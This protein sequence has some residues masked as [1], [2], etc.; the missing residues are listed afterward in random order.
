MFLELHKVSHIWPFLSVSATKLLDYVDLPNYPLD[1][2]QR[3][4]N[5]ATYFLLEEKVNYAKPLLWASLTAH[6][7]SHYLQN[8]HIVL[9]LSSQSWLCI[10][11]SLSQSLQS[12]CVVLYVLCIRKKSRCFLSFSGLSV[13][14]LPLSLW[15]VSALEDF[16]SGLKNLSLEEI[17]LMIK[18]IIPLLSYSFP[19]WHLACLP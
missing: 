4:Q 3:A 2:L 1:K 9:P 14:I 15:I 8:C 12:A 19:S 13:L 7:S 18:Y 16:K 6:P 5:N 10:L 11:D 17:F